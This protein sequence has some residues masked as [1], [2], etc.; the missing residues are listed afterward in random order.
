MSRTT[1]LLLAVLLLGIGTYFATAAGDVTERKISDTAEDRRYAYRSPNDI[2]EIR[3]A[4]REGHNVVLKR[5][6]PSGWTA[7][8]TPANEHIM[9]G[10]LTTVR[11]LDVRSLPA[12]AMIPNMIKDLAANGILVQLYDAAGNK[13]RGYYIGGVTPD[14]MGNYAIK[15][16]SEHPYIVSIPGFSGNVRFRFEH[17]DDEWRDKVYFRVDPERVQRFSIEYPKQRDQSFVLTSTG[18]EYELK[19]VYETGQPTRMIPRGGVEGFLTN[20]E[21][22]YVNS[23]ENKDEVAI[24]LFKERVPFAIIRVKEEGKE[25][26]DM[27]IYPR[28]RGDTGEEKIGELVKE[29]GMTAYSAFING[30]QDWVLLNVETLQPLLYGYERF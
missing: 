26:Q 18:E 20:F 24:K 11:Q 3:V 25:E 22:Y 28:Y 7:D 30:G 23:Y 15:E 19:P 10:I 16:G 29:H 2:H 17:W 1:I 5:G 13:L 14:G 21:K 27:V 8:G 12:Q 6:G 4:D 9:K